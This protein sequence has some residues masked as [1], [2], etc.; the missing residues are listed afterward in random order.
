MGQDSGVGCG[1]HVHQVSTE[2]GLQ[3][4]CATHYAITAHC[5]RSHTTPHHTPHPSALVFFIVHVVRSVQ[6]SNEKHDAAMKEAHL[7]VHVE[8]GVGFG[9]ASSSGPMAEV[10]KLDHAEIEKIHQV[11]TFHARAKFSKMATNVG[12]KFE[13]MQ[14]IRLIQLPTL[15]HRLQ[16]HQERVGVRSSG[17]GS[18]TAGAPKPGSAPTPTPTPTSTVDNVIAPPASADQLESMAH[19]HGL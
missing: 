17:T 6:R 14:L 11:S 9:G 7:G 10:G 8:A 1:H 3:P 18:S 13:L 15:V 12:S 2:L 16:E 5:T 4:R 19:K